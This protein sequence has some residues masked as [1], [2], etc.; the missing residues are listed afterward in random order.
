M[1][2]R[3]FSA[4]IGFIAVSIA[5]ALAVSHPVYAEELPPHLIQTVTEQDIYEGMLALGYLETPVLEMEDCRRAFENVKDCVVRIQMGNAHGSGIVWEITPEQIIVVTNRH[6]LDYWKED[7]SYVHFLQGCD[8]DAQILGVSEQF[9][10]GFVAV[11]CGQLTYEKLQEIRYACAD[12]E[13]YDSLQPGDLMFL[14]DPGT[15][16]EQAQYYE[17]SVGDSYR[18]IEDF[19][20]YMLYGY[21]FAKAGMSGGGTFDGQG[22]LIGMTTGGTPQNEAA[23]VPLPDIIAA[24]EEVVGTEANNRGY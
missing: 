23:S 4:I 18:Y 22:Y 11:D 7:N 2:H 6:V 3:R 17:G 21:C 10:A 12:E 19:D 15:V 13:A 8:V 5:A 20:A 14:I 9:D 1:R 24:Y 16:G